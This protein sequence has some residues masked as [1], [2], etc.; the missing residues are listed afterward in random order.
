[1]ENIT[2]LSCSEA[3]G[4]DNV[5]NTTVTLQATRVGWTY[6]QQGKTGGQVV[7]KKFGW[8]SGTQ[9]EWSNF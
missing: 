8:D 4:C 3:L 9:S 7:S 2:V 5:M 1:M 6:Y